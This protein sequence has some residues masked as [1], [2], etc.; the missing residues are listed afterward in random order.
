MVVLLLPPWA[1]IGGV[2]AVAGVDGK[3]VRELDQ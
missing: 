2:M 3:H 1:Y